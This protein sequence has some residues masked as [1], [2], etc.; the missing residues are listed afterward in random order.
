MLRIRLDLKN[1]STITSQVTSQ[2]VEEHTHL[3][4]SILN[5]LPLHQ[6]GVK[7]SLHHTYKQVDQ[8]IAKVEEMSKAQ[9]DQVQKSQSTQAGPLDRAPPMDRRRPSPEVTA[10][11]LPLRPARFE[12]VCVRLQQYASIC[13]PGCHCVCHVSRTSATPAL[14]DRVLGRLFIGYAGLPL[15]SAK[16][17]VEE[18]EKSQVPHVSLEYWFPLGF[19]WSH[20]IRL[21]MD[22]QGNIGPQLSLTTLR[23]IPDSAQC[24]NFA[25]NGN[26]NGLKDLFARGLA[27]PRDVSGTRGYSILRVSPF[28]ATSRYKY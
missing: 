22:Y 17:D 25:L 7:T 26:I 6:N 3:R 10:S 8:R 27:S 2:T 9:A 12:G 20:I 23:R 5:S 15:I 16:C 4:N 11:S 14:V 21:Q 28:L 18:C 19:F 24:V 1:L 13:R